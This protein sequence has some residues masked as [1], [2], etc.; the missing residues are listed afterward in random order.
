[1]RR[2]IAQWFG[3][4][5][6]A[7]QA[8]FPAC[9]HDSTY[10]GASGQGG[11]VDNLLANYNIGEKLFE[12]VRA[13][14]AASPVRPQEKV[15][16]LDAR[17]TDFVCAVNAV[18][19]RDSIQQLGPTILSL[20]ALVDDGTLPRMASNLAD[21][22]DLLV[23]EPDSRTLR[24]FV[25]LGATRSP[26]ASEDILEFSARMANYPEVDKL[27]EAIAEIIRAND[28][29][30]DRG[31]PNGEPDL[32]GDV[33]AYA[34]RLLRQA[35]RAPAAGATPGLVDAV[36]A[37]LLEPTP[38]RAQPSVFGPPVWV[39]RVDANGNPAVARDP[40]TGTLFPPFTDADGDGV[41]DVGPDGLPVDATGRSV[42]IPAFGPPGAPG[43]DAEGRALAG[44]GPALLFEYFDAKQTLL[45]H[46]LQLGGEALRRHLHTQATDIA[47]IALGP[48]QVNDAGTPSDPSDDFLG[49]AA[50]N[51]VQD[52]VYGV[53]EFAAYSELPALLRAIS[54]IE[55]TDPALAERL[56]VTAGRVIERL[57]PIWLTPSGPPSPQSRLLTDRLVELADR[58][59][60]RGAGR[61]STA[62][63]LLDLMH[64]LGRSARALP[65]ALALMIDYRTL[66]VDS[67]GN[68]VAG[69]SQ[70]VDRTLPPTL[71][72][73]STAENRSILHQL[74]DLV[75]AADSCPTYV[76][77][78]KPL[79]ETLIELMADRSAGTV[80][81]LIGWIDSP[82][83]QWYLGATCPQLV[84]SLQSLKGLAAS[85][86]LEGFLPIAKVFVD[87]G[88][89]RLLI[90]ILKALDGAYVD[91]LRPYEGSFSE[92]L[93]SGGVE[94]IFDLLDLLVAG[95]LSPNGTT[96]PVRDPV[97]GARAIDLCA[98]AVANLLAHP[99]AG[100]PGRNGSRHAT[101][102]HLVADP[103]RAIEDALHAANGGAAV[104]TALAYEATDL[105]I[106]R[107]MN[108]NGTPADPSDDFEQLKN[109]SV[110]PF[111]GRLLDLVAR[112][113]P[114]EAAARAAKVAALQRDAEAYLASQDFAAAADLA[115]TIRRAQGGDAIRQ[116]TVHLLTPDPV[117]RDD[118]FGGLLKILAG[119]LQMHVDAAPLRDIAGFMA[120][121]F[122]PRA[123]RIVAI[124]DGANRVLQADRG[125]VAIALLRNSLNEAPA[126]AGLPAGQSPAEVLLSIAEDVQAA[127]GTAH[128]SDRLAELKAFLSDAVQY[129]RDPQGLQK[130][131]DVIRDRPR[132]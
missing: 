67:H 39:V 121:L 111:L 31:Q 75:E 98:D 36:L 60:A 73:P 17:R 59:F 28:G 6:L 43:R 103:F 41:A 77:A 72:G 53:L 38:P 95:S 104:A 50:Q 85:G 68:P 37:E 30:D 88:Q 49:F 29:K 79:S 63:L 81:M 128:A 22:L 84:P 11:L 19:R 93:K 108:D 70:L 32:V 117:A 130:I 42:A 129:I 12:V 27:F 65:G 71:P 44:T 102:L 80:G 33:L 91:V 119:A 106:E 18:I 115:F 25:A 52:L 21:V 90:D 26:L 96:V 78:G 47:E 8:F 92:V 124:V 74:L 82:I 46:F 58:V 23:Q 131:F 107:T 55:R 114:Q 105:L 64:R 97:T 132:S 16:A 99:A 9:Q 126:S 48:R 1:M 61:Q 116:A 7:A 66:A 86:A 110:G 14:L 56:L 15:A 69:Q 40:S 83:I 5:L 24:A 109:P 3:Y 2:A 101:L 127:G 62:R 122:D 89:T 34:S 35:A 100:V 112:D 45:S 125:K 51:P 76:I 57:R 54:E 87:Q 113:I 20:F 123:R 118:V 13:R 10:H 4:A 120:G 94:S